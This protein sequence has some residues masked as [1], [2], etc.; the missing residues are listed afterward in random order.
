MGKYCIVLFRATIFLSNYFVPRMGRSRKTQLVKRVQLR[1]SS[2]VADVCDRLSSDELSEIIE[3]AIQAGIRPGKSLGAVVQV[4]IRPERIRSRTIARIMATDEGLIQIQFPEKRDDFRNVVYPLGY[5]WNEWCWQRKV[6]ADVACDRVAE[7]AHNLLLK[8]FVV[9]VDHSEIRDRAI[10]GLYEPEAFRMVKVTNSG[11]YKDWFV[12]EYPRSDDFY[13]DLMNLTGAK[14]VDKR[15]KVPQE[16]FAEVEDFAGEN[17]FQFS[18]KAREVLE[19]TKAMW[20]SAL[21]VLPKQKKRNKQKS[22][23]FDTGE[24]VIPDA[25]KD[26]DT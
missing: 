8:G 4:V 11:V 23:T 16:H 21:L 10:T 25:L 20:E 17:E 1:L 13:E 7:V 15:V 6:S 18:T 14:Y 9:Q 12:F 22:K 26:D 19:N 5:T 24:V 3:K 2:E